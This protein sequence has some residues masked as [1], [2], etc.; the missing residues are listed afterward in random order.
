MNKLKFVLN[1]VSKVD[2]KTINIEDIMKFS[3]PNILEYLLEIIN[4]VPNAANVDYYIKIVHE[5]SIL[6]N[7]IKVSNEI[8]NNSYIQDGAINDILDDAEIYKLFKEDVR[9]VSLRERKVPAGLLR[10]FFI[11]DGI[12][13]ERGGIDALA[14]HGICNGKA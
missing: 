11:R 1:N 6:R 12:S 14:L 3:R 8:S 5:K 7:L 2:S 4:S 13:A 10:T 9:N